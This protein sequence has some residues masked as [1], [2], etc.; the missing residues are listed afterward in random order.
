M[1]RLYTNSL[2][3]STNPVSNLHATTCIFNNTIS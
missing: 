1:H 2:T 3:N